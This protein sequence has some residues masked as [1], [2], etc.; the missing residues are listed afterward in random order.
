MSVDI[1]A[2]AGDSTLTFWDLRKMKQLAVFNET[3]GAEITCAQFSK[4][5]PSHLL[6]SS[7]DGMICFYDLE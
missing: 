5:N 2:G 3:H 6:A 4:I 7:L 1:L